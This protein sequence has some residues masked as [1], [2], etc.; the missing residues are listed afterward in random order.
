[1]I[2][3]AVYSD[4][5]VTIFRRALA[6]E[7][8]RSHSMTPVPPR[9]RNQLRWY[10]FERVTVGKWLLAFPNYYAELFELQES[11]LMAKAVGGWRDSTSGLTRSAIFGG[12]TDNEGAR[13]RCFIEDYRRLVILGLS[14]TLRKHFSEELDACI[15]MDYNLLSLQPLVRTEIGEMVFRAKYRLLGE[16]ARRRVIEKIADRLVDGF[17]RLPD[18]ARGGERCVT[19]IP[20]RPGKLFDLPMELAKILVINASSVKKLREF[21]PLVHPILRKRRPAMKELKLKK[22]FSK[23]DRLFRSHAVRLSASVDGCIVYVIDDLYQSG[24]TIWSYARY[25]KAQGASAVLGLVCEKSISDK[26][27]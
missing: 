13:I 6:I 26:R 20:P 15:A 16:N 9:S 11:A 18:A 17:R 23:W 22:R 5:N 21:E 7:L 27:A 14:E 4:A 25:L 2:Q 19:Y 10:R 1:M 8:T 3:L 12:L 24:I